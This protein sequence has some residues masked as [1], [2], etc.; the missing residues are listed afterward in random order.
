MFDSF[1]DVY[2]RA[3]EG[4]FDY[5]YGSGYKE[6]FWSKLLNNFL[7]APAIDLCDYLSII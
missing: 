1:D 3:Q 2:K 4:T 5:D 7:F 6:T